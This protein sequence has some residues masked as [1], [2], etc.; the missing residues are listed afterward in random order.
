ML[1]LGWR[2]CRFHCFCACA[3]WLTGRCAMVAHDCLVV[4]MGAAGKN[5][6]VA[7]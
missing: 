3:A 1:T 4:G 5:A 7:N 2:R 6:A